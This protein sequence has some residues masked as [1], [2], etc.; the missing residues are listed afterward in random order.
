MV[1]VDRFFKMA[2]FI[3]LHFSKGEMDTMMVAKL[4]FDYIFKFHG[5]PKKIISD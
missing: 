5:L 2:H 4:L 3:P 1:V